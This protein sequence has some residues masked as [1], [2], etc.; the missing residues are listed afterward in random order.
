MINHMMNYYTNGVT[1]G[2]MWICIVIGL[3]AIVLL[4]VQIIKKSKK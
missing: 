3:L 1:T 2:W 4:V